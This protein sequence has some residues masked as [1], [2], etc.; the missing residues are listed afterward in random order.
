MVER[1]WCIVIENWS[2]H[3]GRSSWMMSSWMLTYMGLYSCAL[4]VFSDGFTCESSH[5][6]LTTLK[7]LFSHLLAIYCISDESR[8][9]LASIR[10]LGDCPCPRCEIPLSKVHNIGMSLDRTQRRTKARIDDASRRAKVGSARSLIYEHGHLVNSAQVERILKPKSLVPTAVRIGHFCVS[11][12]LTWG[13]G[14]RM[15]FQ[16]GWPLL[17]SICSL[18]LLLISCMNLR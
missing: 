14:S 2:M 10:N 16:K 12:F 11:L 1:S 7:S 13:L 8:I 18:C 9:L 3:N 5:I 4:M 6:Q 15:P 17:T